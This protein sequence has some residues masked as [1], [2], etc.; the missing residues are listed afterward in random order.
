MCA[1]FRPDATTENP[2]DFFT[3]DIRP[4]V[5]SAV[6]GDYIFRYYNAST[7][8][9]KLKYFVSFPVFAPAKMTH[10]IHFL[11]SLLL[12]FAETYV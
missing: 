8:K 4:F 7:I 9:E 6:F 3:R 11:L 1:K 10:A 12:Y 2:M 5:V